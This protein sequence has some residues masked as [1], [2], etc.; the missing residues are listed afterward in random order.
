MCQPSHPFHRSAFQRRS[1]Y[2]SD[3]FLN[4]P[5]GFVIGCPHDMRHGKRLPMQVAFHLDLDIH[6]I[7]EH[8][9]VAP[10]AV[11]LHLLML[12][13]GMTHTC[14]QKGR[15][16]EWLPGPGFVLLYQAAGSA[17]IY[18]HQA[19]DRVF[20]PAHPSQRHHELPRSGKRDD[21]RAIVIRV[22]LF[23]S[24]REKIA[25][26]NWFLSLVIRRSNEQRG[27]HGRMCDKKI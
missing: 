24:F 12:P 4:V 26:I 25:A 20:V 23:P 14:C 6:I 9:L 18:F 7:E 3:L 21:A 2:C 13:D 17:H 19:V 8:E 10:G 5:D 15:E 11:G 16:G 27:Y 22:H 1:L